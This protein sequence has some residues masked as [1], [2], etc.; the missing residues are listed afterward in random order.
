MSLQHRLE[1]APQLFAICQA[2]NGQIFRRQSPEIS[3]WRY[4]LLKIPRSV[5]FCLEYQLSLW[6]LV[7]ILR[8]NLMR[9]KILIIF[10]ICFLFFRNEGKKHDIYIKNI[11]CSSDKTMLIRNLTCWAKSYSRT[12]STFNIVFLPK[13]PINKIFAGG[14]YEISCIYQIYSITF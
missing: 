12:V 6:I 2:I 4:K 13:R 14:T 7:E 10:Y 1:I 3:R 9:A 5:H 11:R 8:K